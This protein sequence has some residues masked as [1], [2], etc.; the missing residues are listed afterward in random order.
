MHT[1]PTT[2]P[3]EVVEADLVEPLPRSN[4]GRTVLVVLQ[5]KCTKWVEVQPLRQ[6]TAPTVTRVLKERVFLRHGCL[7]AVITYNG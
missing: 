5:D 1:M 7:R 3:W 4:K 6:A 2:T